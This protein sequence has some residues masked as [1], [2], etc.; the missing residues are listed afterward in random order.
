LE[1]AAGALLVVVNPTVRFKVTL[2]RSMSC[3]KIITKLKSGLKLSRRYCYLSLAASR[4]INDVVVLSF[5]FHTAVLQTFKQIWSRLLLYNLEPS[6]APFALRFKSFLMTLR[7]A[8]EE[9]YPRSLLLGICL[10]LLP[11]PLTYPA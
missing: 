3:F 7:P 10:C 8:S 5:P 9:F 1:E 2:T 4:K 11:T 6:Q